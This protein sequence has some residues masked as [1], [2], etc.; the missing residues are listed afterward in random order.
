MDIFKRKGKEQETYVLR[1]GLSRKKHSMIWDLLL[2]SGLVLLVFWGFFFWN[3][4]TAL[5][6]FDQ[7]NYAGCLKKLSRVS[8]LTPLDAGLHYKMALAQARLG[9]HQ[10]VIDICRKILAMHPSE[11]P[12]VSSGL[13]RPSLTE[14]YLGLAIAHM[15]LEQYGDVIAYAQLILTQVGDDA[16]AY[17]L[18]ADAHFKRSFFRK[19]YAGLRAARK[20][21]ARAYELNL[22][23]LT[24][25]DWVM[26]RALR[27][28][29]MSQNFQ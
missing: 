29:P 6:E 17:K 16:I 1:R 14:V 21:F 10:E 25:E 28:D 2:F 18:L 5:N 27:D 26:M 8:F 15:A 12:Q 19:E 4:Q 13:P 20:F 3:V 23:V 9:H 11:F 24:Q 22:N 7:G